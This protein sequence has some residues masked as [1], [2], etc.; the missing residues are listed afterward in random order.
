[1]VVLGGGAV[2]EALVIRGSAIPSL[3]R[4]SGLTQAITGSFLG[5]L[6]AFQVSH[7]NFPHDAR[8][9]RS[10]FV[11]LSLRCT[12]QRAMKT[13]M[14]DPY[15]SATSI[16]SS[17]GVVDSRERHPTSGSSGGAGSTC[18][19][20]VLGQLGACRSASAR[21]DGTGDLLDFFR[22]LG[23]FAS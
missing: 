21:G 23:S 19:Q 6:V 5:L 9:I 1:M 12:T 4:M 22:G 18:S 17:R 14:N 2:A 3:P 15:T 16:V 11:P 20:T 10:A 8:L 13:I 7:D